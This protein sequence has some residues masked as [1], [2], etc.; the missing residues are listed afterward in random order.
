MQNSQVV[1]T[2][3]RTGFGRDCGISDT[4][5]QS[6]LEL[7]RSPGGEWKAVGE[8]KRPAMDNAVARV[9]RESNW[10]VDMHDSL[11]IGMTTMHT[12]QMCFDAQ[13]R[14][15]RMIDRFIEAAECGCVRFTA[16]TYGTDGRVMRREQSFMKMSTGLEMA[17]PEATKT[18]PDVWDYRRLEQLPFYSLVKK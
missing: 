5:I 1:E 4:S 2:S 9:W 8:G 14:I 7:S 17:A 16:I 15:S 11:G 6:A 12:G 18:F 13:G 10:M 3:S